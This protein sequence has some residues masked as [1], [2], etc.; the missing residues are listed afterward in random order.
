MQMHML[1][2]LLLNSMFAEPRVIT[3]PCMTMQRRTQAST[4][5]LCVVVSIDLILETHFDWKVYAWTS[6]HCYVLH[7][8][9]HTYVEKCIAGI[10]PNVRRRVGDKNSHAAE[11]FDESTMLKYYVR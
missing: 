9:L 3:V 5:S 6:L 8:I 10:M 2:L 11:S 7:D 1:S 4:H